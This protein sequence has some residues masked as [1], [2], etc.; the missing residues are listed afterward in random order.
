MVLG[1]LIEYFFK[2]VILCLIIFGFSFCRSAQSVWNSRAV[3]QRMDS[4]SG[5]LRSRKDGFLRKDRWRLAWSIIYWE[6]DFYFVLKNYYHS[7]NYGILVYF[8]TRYLKTNPSSKHSEE[9]IATSTSLAGEDEYETSGA[10][11]GEEI[12]GT[13]TSG[14]SGVTS[15]NNEVSII[16]QGLK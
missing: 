1:I 2:D 3:Y 11:S 9:L 16:H 13:P 15:P 10:T 7:K 12:W 5:H 6:V 4:T 14:D 8:L